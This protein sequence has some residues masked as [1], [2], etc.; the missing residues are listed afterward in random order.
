MLKQRTMWCA[1]LLI[2]VLV[3]M[4]HGAV[5]DVTCEADRLEIEVGETTTVTVWAKVRPGS[6]AATKDGIF[7]WGADLLL[8][9]L[10][11]G[12]GVSDTPDVPDILGL[13]GPASIGPDWD[14]AGSQGQSKAWG[15]EA[16]W[17]TQAMD[18]SRGFGARV[19]LFTVELEGKALGTGQLRVRGNDIQGADV[20]THQGMGDDTASFD[21]ATTSIT[22]VPEPATLG[23]LGVGA[24]ALLR[25]RRG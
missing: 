3:S 2:C 24:L 5:I 7:A 17:D 21:G 1:G 18:Q 10:L 11:L 19:K 9:D 6:G 4:A 14:Q 23:L 15:L 13:S 22:V 8:E 16:I 20:L 12:S 25:R